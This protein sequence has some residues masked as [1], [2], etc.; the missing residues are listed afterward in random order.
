MR[1]SDWSSDVC[2][3]DLAPRQQ[4]EGCLGAVVGEALKLTRLHLLHK[5]VDAGVLGVELDADLGEAGEDVGA[6]GLVGGDDLAAVANHGRYAVIVG[7]RVLGDG[8]G[9]RD[10]LWREGRL[11]SDGQSTAERSWGNERVK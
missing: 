6:G 10:A 4:L 3:S 9:V 7:A 8:G 2:S 11:A 1:I 5:L